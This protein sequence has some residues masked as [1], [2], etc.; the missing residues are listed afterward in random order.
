M[1]MFGFRG[2]QEPSLGFMLLN[3]QVV[4]QYCEARPSANH[5]DPSICAP[6]EW[7]TVV[8]LPPTGN[9]EP[10]QFPGE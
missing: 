3:F 1:K 8:F 9:P 2:D 7:L 5:D 6:N 4:F 10:A